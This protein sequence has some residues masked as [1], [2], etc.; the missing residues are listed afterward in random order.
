MKKIKIWI[1]LALEFATV[2]CRDL[3]TMCNAWQ[4]WIINEFQRLFLAVKGFC[5]ALTN[6]CLIPPICPCTPLDKVTD[7]WHRTP[8]QIDAF[9]WKVVRW[10]NLANMDAKGIL[11]A[12]PLSLHTSW[13][14]HESLTQNSI[15][16]WCILMKSCPL[17]KF[18]K[19][20]HLRHPFCSTFVLAHLLTK[21]WIIGVDQRHKLMY[22]DEKLSVDWILKKQ[23]PKAS[24]LMKICV[25]TKSCKYHISLNNVLPYIMSSLE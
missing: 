21:L 14:S 10:L 23:M 8:S 22:F 3:L 7:H 17:T 12:H 20:G 2:L 18:C 5:R 13:Q 19:Y 4:C 24:Y 25:L 1:N 16:N 15:T 11:F 6:L 9:W